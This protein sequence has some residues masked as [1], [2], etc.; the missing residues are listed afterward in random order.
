MQHICTPA[1]ECKIELNAAAAA[2]AEASRLLVNS[3]LFDSGEMIE[4]HFAFVRMAKAK[5]AG[6]IADYQD[7]LREAEADNVP[8]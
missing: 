7:H 6:A 5:V 2:L 1:C 4:M 8:G 3:I